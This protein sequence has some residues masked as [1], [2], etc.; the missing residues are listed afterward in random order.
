MVIFDH[1][2]PKIIESTSSFPEFVP[3]YK[4][5]FYSICSFWGYSQFQISMTRLATLNFDHAHPKDFRSVFNFVNLLQNVSS[6]CI[7]SIHSICSFL[8][9]RQ[10]QC[11]ISTPI[12][13]NAHP[14]NFQSPFNLHELAPACKNSVNSISSFLRYI[15]ICINMEKMKLFHQFILEKQLI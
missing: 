2:H 10:F 8:K 12:F 7:K 14:K 3:A 4:K 5:S 9:Y 15:Q 13:D 6:K 11:S 1:A